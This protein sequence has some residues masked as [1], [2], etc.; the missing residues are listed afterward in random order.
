MILK[1]LMNR[2][3]FI[4][5]DD[6]VS[7]ARGYI[8]N[9]KSLFTKTKEDGKY[10]PPPMLIGSGSKQSDLEMSLIENESGFDE[11]A[12]A[13]FLKQAIGSDTR[14]FSVSPSRI[15]PFGDTTKATRVLNLDTRWI[16]TSKSWPTPLK[17][18]SQNFDFL[19]CLNHGMARGCVFS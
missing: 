7:G 15:N 4:S 8:P 5:V 2:D 13:V 6:F 18:T 10:P 9:I 1:L 11:D 3:D 12:L 19:A 16:E 14:T 17:G